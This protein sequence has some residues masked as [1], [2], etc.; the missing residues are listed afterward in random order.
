MAKAID[1]TKQYFGDLLV[2]ERDFEAQKIHSNERQA[3]WKCQCGQ[4]L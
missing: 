2:L 4:V 3:W 1:L